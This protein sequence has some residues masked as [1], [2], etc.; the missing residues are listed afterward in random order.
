MKSK[1]KESPDDEDLS[2]KENREKEVSEA[3][4]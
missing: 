2:E 3:K 4:A 1:L